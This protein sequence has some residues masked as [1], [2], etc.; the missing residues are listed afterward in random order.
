MN[1]QDALAVLS[2][3][4]SIAIISSNKKDLDKNLYKDNNGT[5]DLMA[6]DLIALGFN[7]KLATFERIVVI[8]VDDKFTAVLQNEKGEDI[9]SKDTIHGKWL[10]RMNE[11]GIE[12]PKI[13]YFKANGNIRIGKTN[14]GK[15]EFYLLP[16]SSLKG[17]NKAQ[18]GKEIIIRALNA[19]VSEYNVSGQ[20]IPMYVPLIGTG[21]SRAHLS[22][23]E[24]ISLIKESLLGNDDG[25]FG[26]VKI[27]V[28]P[29]N[30]DGLDDE[31]GS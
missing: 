20:G 5:I 31:Y 1:E 4:L 13:K 11:L 6:G 21:R 10:M 9:I 17:R 24:S 29:K 26:E 27:V 2:F 3:V 30:I 18:S 22:L 7:K 23:K 25:F 16:I 12:K 14:V 15:T 8:P 19:L 28:H